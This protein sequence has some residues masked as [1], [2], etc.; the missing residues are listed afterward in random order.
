LDIDHFNTK[1]VITL[2]YIVNVNFHNLQFTR[3]YAV[4]SDR[5]A[6]T[7]SCLVTASNNGYSSASGLKFSN[8]CGSLPIELFLRV[9]VRITL[10]LAVYRKSVRLGAE[11]LETDGQK[12]F[13]QLNTCGHS[14]YITSFLTRGWDCHLQFLLPL[15]SAFI[16]GSDSRGTRDHILLSVKVKVILRSTVQSASLSWNKAPIWGL[17]PDLYYCPT[18]AGLLMWGAFSDQRTGLSFAG[19]SQQ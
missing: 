7:S 8:N 19:L 12:F 2:N 15:A 6:F 13:S 1:L 9:R 3:A 11:P 17:R 18:V 16:L 14:P 5:S 4:F 10:Q